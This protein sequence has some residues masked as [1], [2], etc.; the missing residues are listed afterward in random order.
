MVGLLFCYDA[1]VQIPASC[2]P[3]FY[4]TMQKNQ[5]QKYKKLTRIRDMVIAAVLV[6]VG[7]FY[8]FTLAEEDTGK[9]EMYRAETVEQTSQSAAVLEEKTVTVESSEAASVTVET[10]AAAVAPE[11]TAAATI[12]VE[13]S[14]AAEASGADARINLNTASLEELDSLPGIGPATAKLILEYRQQYGGFAAPEEIMNVKRIGEKTYEKLK[15]RIR[16]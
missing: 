13:S 3:W 6:F 5:Y 9:V 4:R 8:Y 1:V 15:D 7:I 12:T 14:T 10:T 16:V 2:R 11:T